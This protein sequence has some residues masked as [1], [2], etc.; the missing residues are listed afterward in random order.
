M[1]VPTIME[2]PDFRRRNQWHD[3]SPGLPSFTSQP[4]CRFSAELLT[5]PN[6]WN[7]IKTERTHDPILWSTIAITLLLAVTA[8]A[9]I[10]WPATYAR[11]TL[12]SKAGAIASDFVDLLL[13]APVLL[14]SG[15]KG[16]RGSVPAR[17]V[18]LG[19]LGYLLYNFVL[20][21]FGVHF[22]PLFL[23]YWAT[24]SLCFYAT[25]FSIPFVPLEQIARAC[26]PRAPRKTVAI[27]FLV[28]AIPTA[29][30]DLRENVAAL[31]AGQVPPSVIQLGTPVNL[32][33]ALDLIFLLPGLCVAAYLLL[34]RRASGYALAPAFLALLALMDIELAVIVVVMAQMGCFPMIYPMILS[35]AVLGV[36]CAILLWIYFR[37]AK[38]AV[39]AGQ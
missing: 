32:V 13:V 2:L 15:I 3:I 30:F 4:V 8:V 26:S 17:L 37:L 23:V 10:F 19:T 31:V 38:K 11:E 21:A 12:Y 34:R 9:G 1:S 14:I 33:H 7:A 16:Y 35:F 27:A 22:S 28:L 6:G 25:V 29:A 20:Y 24:L 39:W 18:W 36:G 5:L